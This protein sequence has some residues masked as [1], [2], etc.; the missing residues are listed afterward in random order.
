MT[1][2]LESMPDGLRAQPE[3]AQDVNNTRQ[4]V[5]SDTSQPQDH[6]A[7]RVSIACDAAKD[8]LKLVQELAR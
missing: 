3:G 6:L 1:A 2:D 4:A 8:A 5:A 7:E